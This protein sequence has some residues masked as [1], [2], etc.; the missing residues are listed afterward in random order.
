MDNET[1]TMRQVS[2]E[3]GIPVYTIRYFCNHGLVPNVRRARGGRRVF[4]LEQCDWLKTLCE[5]RECGFRIEEL[6]KYVRLC[7]NG[8]ET[9][10][11]RKALLTTQKHQLRQ[12]A[13]RINH[14]I[15]FLER[16]E[17]L[18]ESILSDSSVEHSQWL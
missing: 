2:Q 13:E 11:E 4:T 3:L 17:E 15:D 9:I 14:A 7:R 10:T 1:F 6:R 8:D 12:E 18:L 5:L 16:R